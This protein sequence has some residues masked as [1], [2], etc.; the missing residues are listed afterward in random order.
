M[1][2][3]PLAKWIRDRTPGPLRHQI[4]R[5]GRFFAPTTTEGIN[6]YD[7]SVEAA[8]GRLKM[9]GFAPEFVVDVGAF[10]GEWTQMFRAIFPE[11]AVFMVEA[12]EQRRQQLE[13]LCQTVRPTIDCRIALLGAVSD[14]SVSFVEMSTGSSVFEER[15]SYSRNVVELKTVA[16]DD[17]LK[18]ESRPVDLIKLD[19]QGYELEVLR[20]APKVLSQTQAVLMECNFIPIN[21]GAPLIAEAIRFMEERDFRVVD[22]C[23]QL[24]RKDGALWQSDLLFLRNAS[25]LLPESEL[26]SENWWV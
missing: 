3:R 12:Q 9:R 16:L 19:V 11:T 20:G 4:T 18:D 26:T 22:I 14:K 17:L 25:P 1:M 5:A 10:K 2:L 6:L 8:L 21:R 15:S 13:E 7:T 24:R 23:S